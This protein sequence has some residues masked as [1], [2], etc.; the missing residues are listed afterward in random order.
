M[1]RVETSRTIRAPREAVFAAT[2]NIEDYA[3]AVP[4]I[5]DVEFLSEQ[6]DGVGTRFRE[7]RRAGRRTTTAR[8]EVT[9]HEEPIRFRKVTD[10]G[11]R[12][13]DTTFTYLTTKEG[14]EVHLRIDMRPRSLW[15]RF[16][17]RFVA[18]TVGREVTSDLDAIKRSFEQ[19]VRS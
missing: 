6:R 13:S 1:A 5:V 10:D 17:S 4:E 7:T 18:P 11:G 19:P 8:V 3:Q 9:E 14:T 15:A 16:T 12:T 2:V